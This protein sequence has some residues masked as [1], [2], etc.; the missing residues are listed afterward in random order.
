MNIALWIVQ[1]L[2]A[3]LF[4]MAGFV[5]LTQPKEKLAQRMKWVKEFEPNTVKAIGA[6]EIL[7]VL[8]LILPMLTGI[9]PFLAPL[10]A[11]GLILTMIGAALTN[12]R[13]K[14]Y[15]HVAANVVLAALAAFVA[16]GRWELFL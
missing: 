10:A 16:Y 11:V 8:G 14:E 3:L 9:L 1:V 12:L 2:L 7:G 13:F 4:G 15:P 5:K 6:V